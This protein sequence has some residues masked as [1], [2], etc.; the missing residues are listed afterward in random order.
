MTVFNIPAGQPFMDVLVAGIMARYGEDPLTLSHLTLLLPNRRSCRAAQEAFLRYN[1]GKPMLLPSIMPLGDIEEEGLQLHLPSDPIPPAIP[2]LKQLLILSKL[3]AARQEKITDMTQAMYLAI[4]LAA[5]LAE[6]HTENCPFDRLDSLVPEDLAEH[7]QHTLSFLHLLSHH[8]PEILKAEGMVDV[9]QHRNLVLQ[10]Q[11]EFWRQHPPAAPVIAAGSTG[12]IPAAAALLRVIERLPHG[13]VILPALECDME[14]ESWN[15]LAPSHPQAGLKQLLELLHVPRQRVVLW[16]E[17]PWNAARSL[18]VREMMRP[19]ETTHLWQSLE[20][21]PEEALQGITAIHSPTLQ[22]EALVIACMMREA[23]EEPGKTVALIT[24]ERRLAR[25][26]S[27]L[28]ARWQIQIDDSAGYPLKSTPAGV[29]LRLV[30]EMA[31]SDAAPVP[32]LSLLKHPLA[33][34]GMEPKEFR[35]NARLLEVAVLRGVR[36]TPGLAGIMEALTLAGAAG[37]APWFAAVEAALSDLTALMAQKEA[38]LEALLAAHLNAAELLAGS[39]EQEGAARLWAGDMGGQVAIFMDELLL[40]AEGFG[41][42][43]TSSYAGVFEALWTGKVYRPRYGL[44]PRLSILSPQEARLHHFDTVILGGIIEG[45]W[46]AAAASDPWMNRPMREKIG[47]PSP[48]QKTGYA[49]HIFAT[50]LHAPNVVLSWCAKSDGMPTV[51]S[52]WLLRLFTVLESAGLRHRLEPDKPWNLWAEMLDQPQAIAS[53]LPPAPKPPLASRPRKLSVTHIERWMRDPY[54]L[55]AL[56]ILK[57]RA[58][59]PLDADPGM[60]EFGNFIHQAL[61]QFNRIYPSLAPEERK[62]AL[63]RCGYQAL[64]QMVNRPAVKHFWLPR[65]E[66]IADWIIT[67]EQERRQERGLKVLSESEG[68]L[69]L[70]DKANPFILT[71]KADRLEL[72][73]AGE[74]VIIDYKTGGVPSQVDIALGISPQ[75]TLEALMAENAGFASLGGVPYAV[76]EL[77]YIRLTGGEEPGEITSVKDLASVVATAKDGL[78]ARIATYDNPDT[79]YLSCPWPEKAPSYNDYEHLA[80][81]KEWGG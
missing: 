58:L 62:A 59:E 74:L 8:W 14:E 39:H 22:Q 68:S 19:A 75:L 23:L 24:E 2:P 12:S 4:E 18:L 31:A 71:A 35:H 72:N 66:R 44:H 40:A 51:P 56:K 20:T 53:C 6:M 32:L 79:P 78:E 16:H 10:A 50:C 15:Q 21:L 42:I 81:I 11:A 52:R 37:L 69:L 55:Y 34:G 77:L 3:V 57:L 33:S 27:S 65:F 47:L 36:V 67:Y 5:F 29:F 64:Q 73:A 7:W 45:S 76:K 25:R 43:N 48:E 63:L 26:V 30:V 41:P 61:D 54:S 80:R 1:G 46:P 9:S 60:A 38:P 28:L 70:G 49:A 13:A 17:Q